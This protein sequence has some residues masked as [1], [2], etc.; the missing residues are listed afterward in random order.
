MDNEPNVRIRPI[1][2]K[3]IVSD[4]TEVGGGQERIKEIYKIKNNKY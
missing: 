3:L 1:Y 4:I 2:R